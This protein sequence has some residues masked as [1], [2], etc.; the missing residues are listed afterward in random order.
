MGKK[1][2]GGSLFAAYVAAMP[3]PANQEAQ[4]IDLI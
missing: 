3:E 4:G 1:E 2:G